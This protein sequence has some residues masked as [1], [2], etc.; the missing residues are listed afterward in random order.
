LII[1]TIV[2]VILV[3]IVVERP[4]IIV[5]NATVLYPEQDVEV[6]YAGGD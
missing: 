2:L 6:R 3:L 5:E 4:L 1:I